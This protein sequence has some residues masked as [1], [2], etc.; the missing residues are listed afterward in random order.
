MD[1]LNRA[2]L[3]AILRTLLLPRMARHDHG[4]VVKYHA[5]QRTTHTPLE[6]TGGHRYEAA[7]A[8]F[9]EVAMGKIA[10]GDRI[11]AEPHLGEVLVG[12]QAGHRQRAHPVDAEGLHNLSNVTRG[13]PDGTIKSFERGEDFCET[14]SR[15]TSR[16]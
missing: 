13:I 12:R 6:R 10:D 2:M 5:D 1:K 4:M 16:C 7:W 8:P 11:R 9:G 15:A 14:H 3:R